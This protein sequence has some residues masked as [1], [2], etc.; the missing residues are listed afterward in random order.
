MMLENINNNI[1]NIFSEKDFLFSERQSSYERFLNLGLPNKRIEDWKYTGF[2]KLNRF[3]SQDILDVTFRL[4]KE[5]DQDIEILDLDFSK[6]DSN[7]Y[8]KP[9]NYVKNEAIIDLNL[10]LSSQFKVIDIKNSQKKPIVIFLDTTEEGMFLPR[11]YI[12]VFEGVS[13]EVLIINAGLKGFI[14]QLVEFNLHKNAKLIVNRV[15]FSET[16]FIET[17][18]SYLKKGSCLNITN[19]SIPKNA[20]RYQGYNFF[21]EEEAIYDFKTVS[22]PKPNSNDDIITKNFHGSSGCCSS[23]GIRAVLGEKTVGTFQSLIDVKKGVKNT[24]AEQDCRAI[25][26]SND[27]YMNAKP[28]M[29]IFN[30]NVVCKHGATIGSL[31]SNQIFYMLTRGLNDEEVRNFLIKSFIDNYISNDSLLKKYLPGNFQ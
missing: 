6:I 21:E 10:A 12:N 19:L 28:E 20:S 22:I 13:A 11:I 8:I 18:I 2:S 9:Q 23:S 7:D 30:D 16:D 15:N 1:K 3:L 17:N 27:A 31:D 26:L 14:N 4:K 29:K 24:I 5:H 25:L